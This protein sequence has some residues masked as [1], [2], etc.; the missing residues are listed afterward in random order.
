MT[1]AAITETRT[2]VTTEE[3]T[4]TRYRCYVCEMEYEESAVLTIGVDR[5]YD[6][7][8]LE[9]GV[10]PRAERTICQHC[11][12]GLF[13]YGA[14]EGGAFDESASTYKAD[15]VTQTAAF[16]TVLVLVSVVV[17]VLAAGAS[18]GGASVPPVVASVGGLLVGVVMG[19]V[20]L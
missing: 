17:G 1:D 5:Q 18:L 8:M 4:E 20:L 12:D 16:G 3:V 15:W 14:A 19:W 13:D 6:D 11:A 9:D 10:E 7:G 2:V